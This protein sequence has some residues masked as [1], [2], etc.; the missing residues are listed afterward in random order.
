MDQ[1]V[2]KYKNSAGK[3]KE[4]DE[5]HCSGQMTGLELK[6]VLSSKCQIPVDNMKVLCA[7]K[8]VLLIVLKKLKRQ[9]SSRF[10]YCF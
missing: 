6:K 8:Y 2:I 1:V 7:G 4:W 10:S 5:V 3:Q 9:V